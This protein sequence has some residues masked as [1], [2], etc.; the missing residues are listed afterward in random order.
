MQSGLKTPD[1]E[2]TSTHAQVCVLR[3][4]GWDGKGP[5][6]PGDNLSRKLVKMKEVP[7]A[8]EVSATEGHGVVLNPKSIPAILSEAQFSSFS[9]EGGLP[10]FT[11]LNKGFSKSSVHKIH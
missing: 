2:E 9:R 11:P 7:N 10:N 1:S 3:R 5:L 6:G 4:V 8:Y